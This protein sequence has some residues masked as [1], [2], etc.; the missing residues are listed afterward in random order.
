M[1]APGGC[2]GHR[3]GPSGAASGG[4]GSAAPGAPAELGQTVERMAQ[5]LRDQLPAAGSG[6]RG[7]VP[8]GTHPDPRPPDEADVVVVGGGVL[9]WSV[10]YW[11][12]VLE[13]WRRKHGMRVL[14]VERDPMVRHPLSRAGL[15]PWGPPRTP[16]I[17]GGFSLSVF[18]SLHGAGGGG[19]PAAVFPPGKYPNVPFLCQLPP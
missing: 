19:D 12:K 4:P 3:A 11:L 16:L 14:V 9:G 13:G 15:W 17:L 5:T 18:Q 1:G 10:A 2:R 7:W 6:G 8:P